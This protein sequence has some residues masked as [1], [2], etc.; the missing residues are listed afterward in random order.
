ML[1]HKNG[2][3]SYWQPIQRMIRFSLLPAW[4][5]QQVPVSINQEIPS[6]VKA[7]FRPKANGRLSPAG[8]EGSLELF[9]RLRSKPEAAPGN[10]LPPIIHKCNG[11]PGCA[12]PT[13]GEETARMIFLRIWVDRGYNGILPCFLR[14]RSS[15]LPLKKAKA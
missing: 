4:T 7:I 10:A 1:I 13:G 11:I 6:K 5:G 15:C 14:G 3:Y 2:C 8:A 9:P 12:G